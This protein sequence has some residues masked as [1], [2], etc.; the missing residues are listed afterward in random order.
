MEEE[1]DIP[2]GLA[3]SRGKLAWSPESP[4]RHLPDHPQRFIIHWWN[5]LHCALF[6]HE[7]IIDGSGPDAGIC[8]DCSTYV[9]LP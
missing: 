2:L 9:G 3:F 5:N 4:W 8:C 1:R 6:G 7:C